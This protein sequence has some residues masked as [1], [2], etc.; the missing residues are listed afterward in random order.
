[1][2][3]FIGPKETIGVSK[4]ED[5]EL[6]KVL[7]K[8]GTSEEMTKLMYDNIVKEESTDLTTERANRVYPIVEEILKVLLKWGVKI[9]EIDYLT[10]MVITSINQNIGKAEE[11][12][13]G[14]EQRQINLID[15]DKVLKKK[16]A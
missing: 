11:I 15:A 5:T 16:D 1:M 7:Y 9:N 12:L 6:V 13:W 2:S 8:D 10:T 3:Q 14:K 4:I